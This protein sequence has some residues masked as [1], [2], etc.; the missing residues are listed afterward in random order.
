MSDLFPAL[1]SHTSAYREG[2]ALQLRTLASELEEASDDGDAL[3][4]TGSLARAFDRVMATLQVPVDTW[5]SLSDLGSA[6]PG[7]LRFWVAHV[8]STLSQVDTLGE[9]LAR[10]V[11]EVTEALTRGAR[12]HA[13]Y[14]QARDELLEHSR[15]PS[16]PADQ[17]LAPILGWPSV[18]PLWR[19]ARHQERLEETCL[20]PVF[21]RKFP[22]M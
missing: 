16:S 11:S 4:P 1:P 22:R 5:V 17:A 19:S 7:L 18:G 20:P 2:V 12:A 3:V 15:P 10:M 9:N 13:D 8:D 6:T 21:P 14:R